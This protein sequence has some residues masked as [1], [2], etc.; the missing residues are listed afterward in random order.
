M[1]FT[2][3]IRAPAA[4]VASEGATHL[5]DEL[6]RCFRCA[7]S[8]EVAVL[9]RVK[10]IESALAKRERRPH[11]DVIND[12]I[13]VRVVVLHLGFL[14]AAASVVR[15]WAV[16]RGLLFV[17]E[18]NR[19]AR[20]GLG[21]YRAIHMDFRFSAPET[22]GLTSACGVEVQLTTYLQNVHSLISHAVLYKHGGKATQIVEELLVDVSE[23]L[24]QID[25][26]LAAYWGDQQVRF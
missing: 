21:H 5:A 1:I 15:G 11:E 16:K 12:L 20:P 6:R 4:R 23:K 14:D 26:T 2:E 22:A 3:E 18:E 24:G 25:A 13:G 9:W 17:E 19:F 10:T 7:S 8:E